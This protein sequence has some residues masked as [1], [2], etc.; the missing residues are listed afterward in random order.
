MDD[1]DG[2]DTLLY[3]CEVRKFREDR[4]I[5]AT[6]TARVSAKCSKFEVR[7]KTQ[8]KTVTLT[9]FRVP[10]VSLA[11]GSHAGSSPW[12]WASLHPR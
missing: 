4:E 5:L 8:D 7:Y 12:G 10:D 2:R 9:I 6:G 1:S 11:A 3:I